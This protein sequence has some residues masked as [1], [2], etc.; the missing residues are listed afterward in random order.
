MNDLKPNYTV[1]KIIDDS[2]EEISVYNTIRFAIKIKVNVPGH[3][4]DTKT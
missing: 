1:I 2:E 4:D 3:E